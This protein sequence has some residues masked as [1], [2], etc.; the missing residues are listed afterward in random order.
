MMTS[1]FD[2]VKKILD[3]MVLYEGYQTAWLSKNWQEVVGPIMKGHS[4]P[5][6]ISNKV[7][8][9]SVD[10]SVWNQAIFI[11]KKNLISKINQIYMKQIIDDIKIQLG[12]TEEINK[13]TELSQEKNCFPVFES[14]S[15]KQDV[16]IL[17]A[18]YFKR[19]KTK[20]KKRRK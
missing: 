17:T 19:E 5:Y 6:R 1:I 12:N 13:K 11:E 20:N 7:L 3:K 14:R 9:V 10:S 15:E 2:V 4:E 8:Y 18:L 16:K